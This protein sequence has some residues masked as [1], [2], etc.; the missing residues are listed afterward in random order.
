[1]TVSSGGTIVVTGGEIVPTSIPEDVRSSLRFSV[2]IVVTFCTSSFGTMMI[3]STVKFVPTIWTSTFTLSIDT[4]NDRAIVAIYAILSNSV[5]FIP[6]MVTVNVTCDVVGT[7]GLGVVVVVVTFSSTMG[8]GVVVVVVTFSST[9]G[10]GVVVVVGTVA[11]VVSVYT[12]SSLL[13]LPSSET[14]F[15]GHGSHALVRAISVEYVLTAHFVQLP[16]PLKDLYVPALHELHPEPAYPVY[17]T[18]Q[19]QSE[20]KLLPINDIELLGHLVA[21]PL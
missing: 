19:V 11:L 2:T 9:M 10:L 21:D 15:S 7:V 16:V 18:L 5:M 8:L 20:P 3:V 6:T 14:W 4:F 12:Q 17:P 13:V 1:M